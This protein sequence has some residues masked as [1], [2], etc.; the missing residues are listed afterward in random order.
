MTDVSE[1]EMKILRA[2]LTNEAHEAPLGSDRIGSSI[3]A[4]SINEAKE[5]SGIKDGKLISALVSLLSQ[6]QLVVTDGE[7]IELTKAGYETAAKG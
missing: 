6:K 2:I 3:W 5:P 4:E 7:T 1:N